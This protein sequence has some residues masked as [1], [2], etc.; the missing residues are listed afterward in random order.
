[1]E[2]KGAEVVER[3]GE[4]VLVHDNGEISGFATYEAAAEVA[5]EGF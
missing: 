4:F 1:M 2:L 5:N 3:N